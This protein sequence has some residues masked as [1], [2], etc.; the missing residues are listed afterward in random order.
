MKFNRI[1]VLGLGYIGLPTA[2]TFASHGI[3]VVGVDVNEH[4]LA[5][6]RRGELHIQ[7]PGLEEA[8]QTALRSSNLTVSEK[9]VEA[10]AFIIAVPTP[11]HEDHFGEVNGQRYKLADMRAVKSAA[12][13]IVPVLRKG[14]LVVLESTSPPRTTVE[15]GRAHV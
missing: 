14:N 5:T 13:A 7:E 10:D 15:I 6:L 11:F 3:Q 8:L 1:C 4:V 2:S 9:P 12:E